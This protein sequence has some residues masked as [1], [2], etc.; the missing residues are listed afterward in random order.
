MSTKPSLHSI[1][2]EQSVLGGL[3][4]DNDAWE[5]VNLVLLSTDFFK[6]EHQIIYET[7]ERLALKH[8]PFDVLIVADELRKNNNLDMIGGEIYLFELVRNTPC[9]ANIVTYAEIVRERL[10]LRQ[11]ATVGNN[12]VTEVVARETPSERIASSAANLLTDLTE[13]RICKNELL[14]L[15]KVSNEFILDAFDENSLAEKGYKTRF[16]RWN[17]KVLFRKDELTLWG[18]YNGHGKSQ[19]LGQI[20]LDLI[21]DGAKVCI[22]SLEMNKRRL[23]HRIFRQATGLREP[24]NEYLAEIK[25]FYGD[26]L[27]L[28]DHV[29]SINQRQLLRDFKIAHKEY[30]CDV[31]VIDSLMKCGLLEDDYNSQK[32]FIDM[33]CDFKATLGVQVHLVAHPR[34]GLNEDLTPGKMDIKGTGTI[35]DL[36]DNVFSVWRNKRKEATIESGEADEELRNKFDGIIRC[37]KQRNGGWEGILPVWFDKNSLQYL[38]NQHVKPHQ[39]VQYSRQPQIDDLPEIQAVQDFVI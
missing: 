13:E 19:F 35:S 17:K 2:A 14:Q 6:K 22:A 27:V 9:L 25:A 32:R 4:L 36:A 5:A 10:L 37:D 11:L 39:Y 15:K 31:F 38:E 16:S 26:K 23:L 21:A 28:F 30:G 8:V 24:S 12:I 34:K 7:I 33:L 3:L 1:E 18:G 29:G 20:T